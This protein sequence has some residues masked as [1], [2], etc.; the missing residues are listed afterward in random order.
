[1]STRHYFAS[2]HPPEPGDDDLL[3]VR[4][5]CEALRISRAQFYVLKG[6]GELPVRILRVGD[7][8]RFRRGD[9]RAF[10]RG[11]VHGQTLRRAG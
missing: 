7:Q 4:E 3:T 6:R 1:M 2:A 11:E 5:L 8:M 10:V 9:V